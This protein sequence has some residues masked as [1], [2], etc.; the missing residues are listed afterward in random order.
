MSSSCP[1]A[2]SRCWHR[3]RG[4]IVHVNQKLVD[5]RSLHSWRSCQSWE[6]EADGEVKRLHFVSVFSK[7]NSCWATVFLENRLTCGG[8]R[9]RLSVIQIIFKMRLRIH[10]DDSKYGGLPPWKH[11]CIFECD[12]SQC[13]ADATRQLCKHD[14]LQ[15]ESQNDFVLSLVG[16][17]IEK[18][19]D[20]LNNTVNIFVKQIH[21]QWTTV[22]SCEF[23]LHAEDSIVMHLALIWSTAKRQQQLWEEFPREGGIDICK[24]NCSKL[25]PPS[26]SIYQLLHNMMMNLQ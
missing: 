9:W 26:F 23:R 18:N 7:K 14:V 10:P 1:H 21:L 15:Q 3:F 25:Q 4:R 5:W 8:S 16:M 2:K 24:S 20:G 19:P 12:V 17:I 13:P 6:G 22:S 11:V